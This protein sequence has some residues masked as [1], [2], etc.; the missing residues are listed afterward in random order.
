ML[1]KSLTVVLLCVWVGAL[2]ALGFGRGGVYEQRQLR[3]RLKSLNDKNQEVLLIN[4]ELQQ[5]LAQN[6]TTPELLEARARMELGFVKSNE[7]FVQLLP[8]SKT[9]FKKKEER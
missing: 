6:K 5:T 1:G 9:S 8:S 2:F 3:L 4:K 7:L